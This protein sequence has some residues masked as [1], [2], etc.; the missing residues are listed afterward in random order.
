MLEERHGTLARGGVGLV[1]V[2]EPDE[3]HNAGIAAAGLP[4]ARG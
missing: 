3:F 1:D 4:I 2:R